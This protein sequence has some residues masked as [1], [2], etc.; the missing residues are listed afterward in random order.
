M[1][2]QR[3]QLIGI[4]LIVAGL[5]C[6]MAALEWGILAIPGIFTLLLGIYLATGV[7]LI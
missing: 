5:L 2:I 3:K 4:A 7:E 1:K 6:L